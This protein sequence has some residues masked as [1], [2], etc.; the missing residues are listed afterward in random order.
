MQKG[1]TRRC[2]TRR[3]EVAWVGR[4]RGF[5][6]YRTTTQN[7]ERGKAGGTTERHVGEYG[8]LVR[9]DSSVGAPR[10]ARSASGSKGLDAEMVKEEAKLVCQQVVLL[11]PCGPEAVPCL[12][13]DAQQ[14]RA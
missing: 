11:V 3:V 14:D 4:G 12:L 1:R 13:L 8:D 10:W 5:A 6:A 2:F 9:D 7:R